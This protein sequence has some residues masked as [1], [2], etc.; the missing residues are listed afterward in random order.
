MFRYFS[1][2]PE[3]FRQGKLLKRTL[4]NQSKTNSADHVQT[5]NRGSKEYGIKESKT[6]GILNISYILKS[7]GLKNISDESHSLT[8]FTVHFNLISNF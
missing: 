5:R 1:G 8:Q 7:Q 4:T 2:S 6:L 3:N